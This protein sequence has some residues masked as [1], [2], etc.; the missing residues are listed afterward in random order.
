M[1]AKKDLKRRVRARQAKTHESYTAALAQVRGA[2]PKVPTVE[3]DDV[4]AM[5]AE[6]GIRCKVFTYPGVDARA[7]LERMRDALRATGG[8]PATERLSKG[9]FEN[10]S[11]DLALA[12]SM[13]DAMALTQSSRRFLLRAR[14]GIGGVS[15]PLIAVNVGDVPVVGALL[16]L[17]FSRPPLFVLRS[18]HDA[19]LPSWSTP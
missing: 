18:A 14:A 12:G 2:R 13:T 5:A 11:S 7:T 19:N 17:P 8:D 9:L 3:L 15:G 6:L 1:T 10:R 16:E 4:T